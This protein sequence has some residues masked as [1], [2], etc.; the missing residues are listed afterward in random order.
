MESVRE[1]VCTLA[2][3]RAY[4]VYKLGVTYSDRA[5]LTR[6]HLQGQPDS[7]SRQTWF[8]VGDQVYEHMEG[9]MEG[10]SL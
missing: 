10:S 3:I 7:V 2:K 8:E 1:Y 9:V 6:A 4:R 5:E